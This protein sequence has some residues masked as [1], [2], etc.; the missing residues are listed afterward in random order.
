VS[1]LP[2]PRARTISAPAL[3]LERIVLAAGGRTLVA[4]LSLEVAAGERLVVVGPNGS[5]KST[6][7]AALA[8]LAEPAAGR[9]ARPGRPPGMLFQDG[10]LWPH[11]SVRRHLQFVDARGDRAW[12]GR[13]LGE[14]GLEELADRKPAALSGGERV[15]LALARAL[16]ARPAWLLLDEPLTHLD[17]QFGDRVRAL[18][19]ALIGELG[20][21]CVAVVH[22][23]DDVR[24]LGERV[25]CLSG[26]GPWW[27]GGTHEALERPP[28]PALAA[29]SGR[30]TLLTARAD[31]AGRVELGLG[32]FLEGQPAGRTV[33]AFLDARDVVAGPAG[34]GLPGTW[35]APDERGGGW[36]AV[37]GRLV[38]TRP[39]G[40]AAGVGGADGAAGAAAGGEPPAAGTPVGLSI[41]GTPRVL[42]A[43]GRAGP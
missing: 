42:S 9:I 22:A 33:T 41:T 36:V 5:G 23:A 43:S 8:G 26:E 21:T 35:A 19:P 4:D 27:A 13:L 30:G 17:A 28:T 18:L 39:A 34:S 11:M 2:G 10:A 37:D 16:A 12:H 32:L 29:L 24:L 25:L 15:R 31:A 1:P 40:D 20:A 14:L 3:L 38:R 6:L 7:L